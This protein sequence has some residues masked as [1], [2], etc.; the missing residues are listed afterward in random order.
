M[1]KII[2]IFSI[3]TYQSILAQVS[4]KECLDKALANRASIKTAK[5][6]LLLA[7]LKTMDTKSKYM[8]Q[9]TL[10]YDYLYNPIIP[11]SIVPVGQFN[12]VATDETRAIRF[13]T[14]WQQN[15]GLTVYQPLIDFTLRNRV[16]ESKINE[17]LAAL[18]LAGAEDEIRFQVTDT[19]I[20]ILNLQAKLRESVADTQRTFSSMNIIR[21]TYDEGRTLKTELNN[22]SINH[23]GSLRQYQK[24][25]AELVTEKIFMIYLTS[26]APQQI[27]G[28]EFTDLPPSLLELPSLDKDIV[29]DS[30]TNYRSLGLQA[31]LIEQQMLT[32][33]N[34]FS[35]SVGFTGFLGA[36]QFS[37]Q[38]N[39]F[40][41]NS[42]FGSSNMG[43]S[44]RLPLFDPN[45][46]SN[47]RRQLAVQANDLNNQRDELK[48]ETTRKYQQ[49]LVE[50]AQIERE[51]NLVRT[52][53][54]LLKENLDIYRERAAAGK[55]MFAELN[56]QE[57]ELQKTESQIDQL[58]KNLLQ[59][60]LNILKEA[61]VLNSRLTMLN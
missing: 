7:S 37:Q 57:A 5:S 42:W 18:D 20:R 59:S 28:T 19:Y 46:S 12:P 33:K 4:L 11:T 27:M 29:W 9:L 30:I 25:N 38:F 51:I 23:H 35:P 50:A 10:A 3:L 16:K 26:M 24:A 31:S 34:R 39:P 21:A 52:N 2:L 8:P 53:R 45:K 6:D 56:T 36:N 13:G 1:K 58:Q 32:D 41:A 15:A 55:Y 60:K 17:S 54:E 49:A 61:G 43:L 14:N 48:A 47:Q 40:E 44:V 22:A